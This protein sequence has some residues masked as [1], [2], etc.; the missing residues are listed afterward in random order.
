MKVFTDRILKRI[1]ESKRQQIKETEDNY[2]MRSF[3]I[4]THGERDG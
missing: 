3:I 1:S 2:I 4:F